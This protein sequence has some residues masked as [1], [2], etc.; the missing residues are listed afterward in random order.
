MRSSKRS[1]I[2]AL[3]AT[4]VALCLARQVPG[5]SAADWPQFQGPNRDGAS[6]ETGLA[7]AWP[8]QGPK[9]LW[10]IALGE[11]FGGPAIKDGKVYVL[12]R[13]DDQKDVLRCLD[14]ATGKE[15]WTFSYDSPGTLDRNGSRTTPTVDDKRIFVVGPFGELHCIDRE[16]RRPVWQKHL[17]RDFG[18]EKHPTWG[19]AQSPSLYKDLVIVAPQT[20][21][22][23]VAAL[24]R[25]TGRV[26]WKSPPLKGGQGYVSPVVA[27]LDGVDQVVMV[28]ALRGQRSPNPIPGEVAGFSVADGRRLWSYDGWQCLI[29]IP[30]PTRVAED[31]L[32]ITGDYGAGATTIQ[33]K[34]DGGG[35]QV[36]ELFHVDFCDSLA[37]QPIVYK[38]HIYANGTGKASQD[39]NGLICMTLD[40]KLK[41]R[42]KDLGKDVPHFRF[43]GIL[44]ADGLLFVMDGDNGDLRM[45]EANPEGYKELAKAS[46]LQGEM[47]WAP[48]A[49]SDGK[50]VI[51]DQTQMKCVDVRNP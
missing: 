2:R 49:L 48:M 51:R 14:L 32:L 50:L 42:T 8:A 43:G 9:V 18:A 33:V 12:D 31:A 15:E 39:W 41:W 40:G 35:F 37:H 17:V 38:G 28:S 36:K 5:A 26:V 29:P 46:L 6:P 25:D 24:D 30:Y 11:G 34:R 19:V 45:V 27:T 20:T 7:R 3:T 44:L 47:V 21:E 13:V 10:I 16:T 23:G 22:A 4:A 1:I